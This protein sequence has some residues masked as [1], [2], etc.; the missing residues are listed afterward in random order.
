MSNGVLLD[1]ELI[2]PA[3]GK[4]YMAELAEVLKQWTLSTPYTLLK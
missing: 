1:K 4:V 3:M 2:H